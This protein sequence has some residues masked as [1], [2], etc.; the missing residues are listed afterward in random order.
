MTYTVDLTMTLPGNLGALRIAG[1]ITPQAA[2][3]LP[4]PV[5]A[6]TPAPVDPAPPVPAPAPAAIDPAR[7]GKLTL[8]TDADGDGSADEISAAQ[9]AAGY[10]SEFFLMQ[11]GVAVFTAPIDGG[12]RTANAKYVRSELREQMQIGSDRVN[13]PLDS[14]VH[15]QRGRFRVDELPVGINGAVTKTVVAQIHGVDKPPPIKVQVARNSAGRVTLYGIYNTMP[16][17]DGIAG[18]VVEIPMGASVEYEIRVEAGRLRLTVDGRVL[19]EISLA[20]WAGIAAYF[21]AGN[22]VQNTPAN[23]T[24]RAVVT[25]TALSVIHSAAP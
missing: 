3:P 16:A 14:G 1:T 15:V 10:A 11:N 20:A 7:Y 12:G 25:H 23:A 2:A 17:G 18:T 13:W 24:G 19:D 9:L 22:Y 21:K 8:P 4:E 5:P 6:P